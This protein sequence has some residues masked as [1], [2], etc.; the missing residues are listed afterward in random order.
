MLLS[1]ECTMERC[2]LRK[3]FARYLVLTMGSQLYTMGKGRYSAENKTNQ[4]GDVSIRGTRVVETP[5]VH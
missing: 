5:R 1:S 2:K 4:N 3:Y